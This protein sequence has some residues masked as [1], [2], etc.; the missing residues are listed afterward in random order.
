MAS[1]A[2]ATS[3]THFDA[4]E[5]TNSKTSQVAAAVVGVLE[6]ILLLV[7]MILNFC[8]ARS[9][10]RESSIFELIVFLVLSLYPPLYHGSSF[11][12][13]SMLNYKHVYL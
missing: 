6:I 3:Q 7:F 9:L 11:A 2:G 10:Y 12:K 5:G 1:I 8:D 4:L 13:L